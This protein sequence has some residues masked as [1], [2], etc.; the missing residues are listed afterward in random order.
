MNAKKV[1]LLRK[2]ERNS[3][4]KN[5]KQMYLSEARKTSEPKQVV[6]KRQTRIHGT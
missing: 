3:G 6:S 5:L 4:A 1:K 2:L